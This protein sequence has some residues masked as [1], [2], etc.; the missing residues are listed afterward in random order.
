MS[1]PSALCGGAP[2]GYENALAEQQI[3]LRG[4]DHGFGFVVGL[5][6]RPDDRVWLGASYTSHKAGGD[7][8]LADAERA[9]VTP[10]PGQGSVCGGGPCF[11]RDRV[12]ALLPETVQA[13]VR[14]MVSPTLDIEASWRF[15]HYGARTALDVSLQSGN[16]RQ[17]AAPPQFLLDRPSSTPRSPSSGRR[18]KRGRR[19]SPSARMSAAPPI[20]CRASIRASTP[21]PRPLASTPPI[22]S[23]RVASSTS[24][25]PCRRPRGATRYS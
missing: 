7:V 10:A 4:F 6:V 12:L 24:A 13:G 8:S 2:C 20:F 23:T 15:V 21:A 5:I 9:Q 19:R 18:G 16:L 17:A 25:T 11:G 3:R 1:Q 14:V 22:A